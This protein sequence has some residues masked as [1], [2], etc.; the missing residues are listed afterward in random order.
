VQI[1]FIKKQT[2]AIAPAIDLYT[3]ASALRLVWTI[4]S[5]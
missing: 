4:M 1:L 3:T 5:H 2:I